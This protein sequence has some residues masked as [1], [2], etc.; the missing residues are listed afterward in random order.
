MVLAASLFVDRRRGVMRL[1]PSLLLSSTLLAGTPW[2]TKDKVL[3]GAVVIAT[4]VDW[5]QTQDIKN[6][7]G[8]YEENPILGRHPS[9]KTINTY[10]ASSI[11]LHALVADQLQG[12]WRTAWQST[13]IVVEIGTVQRNYALGVR[14]NF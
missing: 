9:D 1:F 8:L 4:V 5:R 7:P 2:S 11:L 14:L 6:H 12:K 13:W 3:E 10:F